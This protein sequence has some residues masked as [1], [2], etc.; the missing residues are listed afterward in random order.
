MQKKTRSLQRVPIKL[1][2]ALSNSV[3]MSRVQRSVPCP[4]KA[5]C[6]CYIGGS[7]WTSLIFSPTNGKLR[8]TELLDAFKLN[9]LNSIT[10]ERSTKHL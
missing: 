3:L 2:S 8:N 7:S 10:L 9:Y 5:V 6:Y 4:A 1:A